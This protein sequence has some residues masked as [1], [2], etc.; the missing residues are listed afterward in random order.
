MAAITIMVEP[1]N[2]YV[3]GRAK[4]F[5]KLSENATI[6]LMLQDIDRAAANYDPRVSFTR[7][8]VVGRCPTVQA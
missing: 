5:P 1:R 7:V 8:P 4:N 3:A 2:V 6:R